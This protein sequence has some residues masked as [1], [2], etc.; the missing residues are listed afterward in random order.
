MHQL[1][2]GICPYVPLESALWVSFCPRLV[3]YSVSRLLTAITVI[4]QP[5]VFEG[6]IAGRGD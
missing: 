3:F 5:V 6:F 4:Q 2:C 1:P